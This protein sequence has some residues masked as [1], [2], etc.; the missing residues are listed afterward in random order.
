MLTDDERRLQKLLQALTLL[1]LL[2]AVAYAIGPF[3]PA[4]AAFMRRLPFVGFSVVKVF[5]LTLVCL[6]AAG[7]PRHQRGLVRIAIAGHVVSVS[8]MLVL[9]LFLDTSRTVPLPGSPTIGAVLWG[10]IGL[11]LLITAVLGFFVLRARPATP[12]QAKKAAAASARELTDAERRLRAA[13]VVLGVLFA[14]GAVGYEIGPLLPWTQRAFG[15][16]PFVTNSVVKVG[17]LALIAFYIARNVSERLAY[18]N[19]LV[20]AHV[21]SVL[22]QLVFW[23]LA[24]REAAMP[25][26]TRLVPVRTVLLGGAVLDSGIALVLGMLLARAFRARLKPRFLGSAEYRTLIALA[27]V[28]VHGPDEKVPARDIAANVDR[29]LSRMRAR[30]RWTQRAVL[31]AMHFHPLL[32][33][34]PPVSEMDPE[35]RLEYL[36]RHFYGDF[37]GRVIPEVCRRFVQAMIRVAKQ[38]TY[39]GYYSDS[40]CFEDIGYQP[41]SKRPDHI[42]PVVTPHPLKVMRPGEVSQLHV[43]TDVCVI[44]S[45]AAGGVLAYQLAKTGAQVVVL[46]RGQYV[47][48]RQF[49][50]DEVEMI[51][52]LYSD[53]VFQQTRDY[54]FTVLQGSCV[55]GSTVVN[56]AVC[57]RTP[58]RVLDTW[59]DQWRWDAGI[60]RE[61]LQASTEAIERWLPV[62]SQEA[63]VLNPSAKKFLDGIDALKIPKHELEREV[64][65]ASIKAVTTGKVETCVG[66][67]YCNIG[68]RYDRKLSMLDTALPRAQ[69]EFPDRV[70]IFAECEVT[71]IL[72]EATNGLQRAAAV[73]A[74]LS[75]GRTLT[76]RARKV[77]VS[78]GTIASSWI[79]MKSG[80]GRRLPVGK[81]LSFNMGTPLTA[82]FPEP[83]D[84]YKGLQI[85]HYGR[86]RP[87]RGWVF[88]TWW[89]PPVAQALNMPGWFERHF[90][91]MRRYRHLMAV[92]ILV[93][94]ESEGRVAPAL[95][96]GADIVYQPSAGDRR[97]LADAMIE[98]GRILFAAG[99]RRVMVN[100]WNDYEF[101]SPNTLGELVPIALDPSELTLGTGH[102]QGG[103]ALSRHA[104]RGVV[105]PDFRVHGYSNLFVCDA[106]VFPTSLTVNPQLTIMALA[107]Y[108]APRI[109]QAG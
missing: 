91:N 70:E 62:A 46:E 102:P 12:P 79:L 21:V 42:E 37:G 45:G 48:P 68:C 29:Y 18:V 83:L 100:A 6:Y 104:S 4:S 92:G 65:A 57:F 56:N 95:T 55:G 94:T 49:C 8:A 63:A 69:H 25:L 24:G 97:K 61:E 58:P 52:K 40:R 2:A 39:V 103:N 87:E 34:K 105:G 98:L 53:G 89:N 90:S 71:R 41:Y 23:L 5:T 1:F 16:L 19:V 93:G 86:P 27:D 38:L 64:V 54:R 96:G 33:L 47:E 76:V 81:G 20:W 106:S 35:V 82:E 50:E 11:D 107:H 28:L 80:I 3:I 14:A 26:G 73:K 13:L 44:G 43:D 78:A 30:R 60:N 85:S 66:C 99:A 59:N 51:G 9:L 36:R 109:A 31:M 84:A 7:D 67:G 101:T 77:V 72:T 10:A 32:S 74:R 17:T 15:E 88:E 75:D 22:T 108:A